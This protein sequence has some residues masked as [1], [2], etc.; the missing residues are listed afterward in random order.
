[1]SVTSIKQYNLDG[2]GKTRSIITASNF[3]G[4]LLNQYPN[5]AAAYSLRNLIAGTGAVIRARR[6]S[7]NVEADFTAAEIDNSDLETWV[8]AGNDG[9][10]VTWYDQSGKANNATQS[11][12][13]NQPKIVISG[14]LVTAN[15]KPAVDFTNTSRLT[16]SVTGFNTFTNLSTFVVNVPVLASAADALTQILFSYDQGGANNTTQKGLSYGGTTV[17]L[18]NETYCVFV[19]T[20]AVGRLGSSTYS[21]SAGEQL[22]HSLF[23]L[24]SGTSA[25][26]NGIQITLNLANAVTTSTNSSPSNMNTTSTNVH[27][28]SISG[29]QNGAAQKIQEVIFYGSN[30]TSNRTLIQTNINNYYGIY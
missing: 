6:S 27:F 21:H 29:T 20:A 28:N 16:A 26:K 12:A 24:S 14:T 1:M 11:T 13:A 2:A 5:A 17:A 30:Q 15:G 19:G 4:G 10:V 3:I 7:D 8:G 23:N 9:F 25:Y 22:L 18:A